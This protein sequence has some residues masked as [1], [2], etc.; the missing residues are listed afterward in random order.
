MGEIDLETRR[1]NTAW[2]RFMAADGV[3]VPCRVQD[4]NRPN[5]NGALPAQNDVF[6]R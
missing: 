5:T 2:I 1:I 3:D 6:T 4:S